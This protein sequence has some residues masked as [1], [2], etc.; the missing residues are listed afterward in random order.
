MG[1]RSSAA[2]ASRSGHP[3]EVR[4]D[5]NQPARGTLLFGQTVVSILRQHESAVFQRDF[6]ILEQ[7]VQDWHDVAFD[8]LEPFDDQ[9]A[10]V[11][12]RIDSRLV[13]VHRTAAGQDFTPLFQ[14]RLGGVLRQS[15][16]LHLAAGFLAEDHRQE[17]AEGAV[18][19]DKEYV[20]AKLIL[21]PH[22]P[23]MIVCPAAT[24]QAVLE[25][26][27][28]QLRVGCAAPL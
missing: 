15:Q 19:A 4:V 14:V 11:Q 25:A 7:V 20:L 10:A 22:P 23:Q 24:E 27:R 13:E 17:P 3:P 28:D 2:G 12:G 1:G 26:E 5:R 9:H 21:L 6:P 16:I 8:F 18:H